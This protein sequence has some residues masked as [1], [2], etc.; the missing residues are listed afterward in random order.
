VIVT[1]APGAR[2]SGS[3]RQQGLAG[4]V[5]PGAGSAD[6]GNNGLIQRHEEL[7]R[8]QSEVGRQRLIPKQRP[9]LPSCSNSS[10]AFRFAS[11][12]DPS[13]LASHSLLFGTRRIVTTVA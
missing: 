11:E 7:N 13:G 6:F 2:A 10:A 5:H 8:S 9:D 12:S 3:R 1:I 4:S